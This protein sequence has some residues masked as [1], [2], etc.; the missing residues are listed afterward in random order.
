M[1]RELQFIYDPDM[2]PVSARCSL[3][4]ELMPMPPSTLRDAADTVM[5]MSQRF[6]EHKRLNHSTQ[7]CAEA[8]S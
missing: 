6:I 7:P 4:S 1:R 5:W 3:C 2:R 8:E